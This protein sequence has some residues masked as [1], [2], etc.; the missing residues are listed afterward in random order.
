MFTKFFPFNFI[1]MI[2]GEGD[3]GGSSVDVDSG[4]DY[5]DE[6]GVPP[7]VEQQ[8]EDTNYSVESG[9][10][11]ED[12]IPPAWGKLFEVLPEQFQKH[13]TVRETLKEWDNNFA[14]V[15]SDYAPYKPLL[16]NQISMED[17]QNSIELT[18]LINANP[19]YVFDELGKRYGFNAEQGQQQ[20]ENQE[21]EGNEDEIPPN[22]LELENNPTL[23][24]MQ[25]QLN[26]FQQMFA[27]QEE[28]KQEQQ[29]V[30]Q[31]QQ[32]IASEWNQLYQQLN[33]PQGKDLP[34]NVKEEIVR[35][36]VAIG[37]ETGTYS[38]I[39]GYKQY[40]D[41]VNYVRNTRANNT[42]PTVMPGNGALPS[43]KKNLGQM[44]EDERVD[45]IA[46]MAK[47]LAEGNGS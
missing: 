25:E 9:Q 42:A 3:N 10:N 7:V 29:I 33:I 47:A 23:K 12:K 39:E 41:F 31:A 18:R 11:S 13:P 43:T 27:R 21:E 22:L 46:A 15:Q 5:F 44:S 24:A 8:Q 6:L 30:Q 17:I 19:R 20:V 35:R 26:E 1:S 2:D 16:E 34:Q 36:S 37:D 28:A 45:H 38:L 32:E 4:S 14:K 40:A